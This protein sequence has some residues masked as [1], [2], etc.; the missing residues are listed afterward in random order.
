MKKLLFMLLLAGQASAQSDFSIDIEVVGI[1]IEGVADQEIRLDLDLG[2][3]YISAHGVVVN[4]IGSAP[5]TGT[6]VITALNGIFCNL[7]IDQNSYTLDIQAS[8][9]GTVSVKNQA[10][11]ILETGIVTVTNVN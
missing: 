1:I 11:L 10:G 2:S 5:A 3:R 8:L 4:E 6:C 9:S 7:Q